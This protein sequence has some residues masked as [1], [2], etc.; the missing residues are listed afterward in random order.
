NLMPVLKLP[1]YEYIC[2]CLLSHDCQCTVY[3][4]CCQIFNVTDMANKTTSRYDS[5]RKSTIY[6]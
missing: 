2:Y 3:A 6:E 5:T 4:P 1:K